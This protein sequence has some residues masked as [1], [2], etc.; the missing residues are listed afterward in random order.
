M[1]T[2]KYIAT[3]LLLVLFSTQLLSC[4]FD[5]EQ[6]T[7]LTVEVDQLTVLGSGAEETILVKCNKDWKVENATIPFWMSVVSKSEDSFSFKVFPNTNTETREAKLRISSEGVSEEVLV[8]QLAKASISVDSEEV[9]VSPQGGNK[10]IE[11][12]SNFEDWTIST[13]SDWISVEKTSHTEAKFS[14]SENKSYDTREGVITLTADNQVATIKIVQDLATLLELD[15][16]TAFF[17]WKG[18]V[19]MIGLQSNKE[20]EVINYNNDIECEL[21]SGFLKLKSSKHLDAIDKHTSIK[22]VSAD[23]SREIN[24]TIEASEYPELQM[25]ALRKLYESTDGDHWHRNDNWLSDKPIHEWYGIT[26]VSFYLDNSSKFKSL[27]IMSIDL[28]GNNLNGE[29]PAEIEELKDLVY[30]NLPNN[31]LQGK[32]PSSIGNMPK[33]TKLELQNNQLEDTFPIFLFKNTPKLRII[34]LSNNILYGDV[35]LSGIEPPE[36][37][38]YLDIKLNKLTGSIPRSWQYN[39]N[40]IET[41]PQKEGYGVTYE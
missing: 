41:S 22:V 26:G 36:H 31:N 25:E 7:E 8:T 21:S 24:V 39:V 33:L 5:E 12:S 18:G 29:L 17:P 27:E 28:D 20:V 10:V 32:I 3:L 19:V 15:T 35:D 14:I 13:E 38:G 16:T 23:K 4:R 37:L 11:V 2:N 40:Y 9:S 1:K 30:L 6:P 34:N